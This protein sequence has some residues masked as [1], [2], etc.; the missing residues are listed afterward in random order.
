[1]E[2][3]RMNTPNTTITKLKSRLAVLAI[4]VAALMPVIASAHGG[5]EHV[6]GTVT[7]VSDSAV[8]VK[9]KAGKTEH[10]GLDAKTICTRGE[11]S[12]Q[13]TDIKVGDRVVIHATEVNEKLVAHTVEIG[14]AAA[15]SKSK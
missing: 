1:M 10:V 12:I 6:V 8:T 11:Q 15:A 2:A 7:T 3:N 14:A 4:L 13:R 9:T 5:E